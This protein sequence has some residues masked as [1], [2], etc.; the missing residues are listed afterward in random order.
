[1][2]FLRPVKRLKNIL[3]LS[4]RDTLPLIFYRD[5]DLIALYPQANRRTMIITVLTGIGDNIL[6]RGEQQL[7]VPEDQQ[8]LLGLRQPVETQCNRIRWIGLG[9][10]SRQP[11]HDLIYPDQID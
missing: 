2:P 4:L 10:L 1:M 9:D 8:P 5:T 7:L 6:D 11:K 3:P